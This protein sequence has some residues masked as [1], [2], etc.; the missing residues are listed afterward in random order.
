MF[1]N[2]NCLIGQGLYKS[3]DPPKNAAK[4]D[5]L[6]ESSKSLFCHF[7]KT[8]PYHMDTLTGYTV[9]H[10]YGAK[11]A[12]VLSSTIFIRGTVSKNSFKNDRFVQ[13]VKQNRHITLFY[14]LL[15]F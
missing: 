6:Q 13:M 14:P 7:R 8:I 12:E 1:Q 11:Y 10:N 5:C 3:A 9:N 15:H 2:L 4:A